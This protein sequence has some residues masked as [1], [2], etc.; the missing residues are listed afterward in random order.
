MLLIA[1][2]KMSGVK[3]G[4]PVEKGTAILFGDGAGACLIT[5]AEGAVRIIDSVLHSDGNFAQDLRLEH[6]G[7]VLMNG[8]SVIMQATRKIPSVIKEVLDRNGV[9]P[10]EVTA[11]LMHQA[12]QNLIDR[13]AR[14][15]GVDSHCFYSNIGRYGNTSSASMLI[16]ASE[17]WE[18]SRPKPGSRIAFA[19]FGRL[20]LGRDPG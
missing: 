7:G 8:R 9:Q 10:C 14:T 20:P 5:Q 1:T 17:W 19:A 6:N 3:F 12:N 13:V 18:A 11:F 15:L 4:N 2:E 16:A